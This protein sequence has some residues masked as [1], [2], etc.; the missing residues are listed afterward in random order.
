M[1]KRS[2]IRDHTGAEWDVDDGVA[3]ARKKG[4]LSNAEPRSHLVQERQTESPPMR[5]VGPQVYTPSSPSSRSASGGIT[6]EPVG[7]GIPTSRG[8]RGRKAR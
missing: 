8:T 4:V 5:D 6:P 2:V 1:M 7:G 3:T